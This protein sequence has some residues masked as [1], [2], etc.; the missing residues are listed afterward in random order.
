VTVIETAARTPL[1]TLQVAEL[2][3]GRPDL[4]MRREVKFTFHYADLG[5]LRRVLLGYGDRRVYHREVS[6]VRSVY[7]DDA[8]LSAC[9]ANIEG[10]GQ[11]TKLRLRWYD[12]PRP[13]CDAFLEAKWR[14][15]RTTGKHR[16]H[17]HGGEPLGSLPYK[18][19][20]AA[21]WAAVPEAYRPILLAH[22]QPV[23][24]VEYHRE[25]FAA[26][27]GRLRATLDY[28]L[29]YY[30]QTGRARISTAFAVPHEGFVILEGK[31][32]LGC[33]HQLREFLHPF[34]GRIRRCSKYV[35]GCHRLHLVRW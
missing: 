16:L 15:N 28:N 6:V 29:R 33:E 19:L 23:V 3:S 34:S 18:T 13:G 21:L 25:H 30:D 10:I 1:P 27:G 2:D 26:P 22:P 35:H 12:S 31:L 9:W 11:R 8:R 32:P 24:L 5:M 20:L 14:V 7:F 17:I 4:A